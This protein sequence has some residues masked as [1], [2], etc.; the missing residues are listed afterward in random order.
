MCEDDVR[1]ICSVHVRI[2][3]LIDAMVVQRQGVALHH[4]LLLWPEGSLVD[5]DPAPSITVARPQVVMPRKGLLCAP[6]IIGRIGERIGRDVLQSHGA[7]VKQDDDVPHGDRTGWLP[8]QD[9]QQA[10]T[11]HDPRHG[12]DH[13]WP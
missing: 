9:M 7:M 1:P 13:H 8:G 2:I 11:L 12:D 5:A 6:G 10:Q 4:D 3:A